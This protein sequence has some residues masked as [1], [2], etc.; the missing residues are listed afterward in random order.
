MAQKVFTCTLNF[1]FFI[2]KYLV[3][4][5]VNDDQR[6]TL[7]SIKLDKYNPQFEKLRLRINWIL[8]GKTTN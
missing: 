2:Q 3:Y 6:I 4:Q 1:S 8:I 5:I 7:H